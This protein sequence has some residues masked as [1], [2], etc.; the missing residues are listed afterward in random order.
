[1]AD[2]SYFSKRSMIPTTVYKIV[3]FLAP[4]LNLGGGGGGGGGKQI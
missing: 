4:H 2:F 3:K 1:M